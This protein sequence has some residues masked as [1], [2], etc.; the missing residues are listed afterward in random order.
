MALKVPAGA[1]LWTVRQIA[2]DGSVRDLASQQS[3]DVL[4]VPVDRPR[5]PN[6]A[7]SLEVTYAQPGLRGRHRVALVAPSL[8]DTPVTYASWEIEAGDRLAIG[9]AGGNMTPSDNGTWRLPIAGLGDGGKR[10]FYRTANLAG[11]EPLTVTAL[12]VPK[13]MAGGSATVLAGAGVAGL[14]LLGFALRRRR[15]LWW[16]LALTALAV[17]AVQTR[18]GVAGVALAGAFGV[19]VLLLIALVR[20]AVRAARRRRERR[21]AEQPADRTD[22]SDPSDVPP[23]APEPAGPQSGAAGVRLL[24]ALGV[25]AGVAV[26]AAGAGV[27]SKGGPVPA[28]AAGDATAAAKAEA[29][30]MLAEP[31]LP[32]PNVE[33][34]SVDVRAPSLDPRAERTAAVS[35]T[36]R[37]AAAGAGTYRVLNPNSVVVRAALPAGAALRTTPRG[38]SLDVARA[39][40]Y[41][42]TFET[43]EAVAERDG[44]W[45]LRLDLPPSLVNRFAL[46]VPAADMEVVSDQAVSHTTAGAAGETRVEGVLDTAQAVTF[47]WKPRAREARLEQAVVYCDVENVAFVR[48]GVVDV[49]A[50]ANYKI[51]QG[52]IRELRLKMPAGVS[53]T[54][55]AAPALATWRLDPAT[56]ELAA[57]LARPVSGDFTLTIGMQ[58]PCGGLPYGATLGVPAAENVQ[59]QRGL[60]A[61][62]AP[63][64]IL[65]RLGESKPGELEGVTPV[66]SSDFPVAGNAALMKAVAD[67]PL[68]RAFRYDDPATVKIALRAEPVQPELRVGESGSF[69]IGDERDVLSGVLDLAVAKSGVFS[70]KLQ[71]PADYDIDTLTG[72]DVSHWDDTRRSG[73]AVEVFFKRRV[74]GDTSINLV[75]TRPQRG[76]PEKIEVPRVTVQDA[77]RHTGRIGVSAERGVRLT[78]EEQQAVS[79]RK[80]EPGEKVQ[81]AALTFDILRPAWQVTLRTQVMAPTLKPEILHRVDLAEGMLQHRVYL[82][83]RIENAGVKYFRLRVPVKEATLS[84]S[85]RNIARVVPLDNDPEAGTGRVWQVELHGKVEDAYQLTGFY[86]QPFDP[87]AGGVAIQAFDCLGVARQSAWLVVTGGGRVQVEPRGEAEGLKIEDARSLPESF[88]AGD[89]SGAIRCYRALRP[90]Y[91]CDLSVVRNG[92]AAVL[93][94]SVDGAQFVTVLSSSGKLLTQAALDL[95]VGDLRFL[96]VELPSAGCSLWAAQVNGAQVAVSR[97][98]GVVNV[99]LENL[100]AD[101]STRVTLVYADRLAGAALDGRR[102]LRAPRFPD[103]PLRNI[104]WTLYVPPEYGHAFVEGDLDENEVVS[105]VKRFERS[106]YESYNKQVQVTSIEI[107]KSNLKNVS[108]LLDSGRQREA[109][110]AL[111]VAVNASQADQTLNEDARIQYRNVVRQQVKMGLVNRREELRRDNN[112]FDEQAPQTAL[113][114]NGGNFNNAFVSQ[115]EEQLS[116]Q[117]RTALDKVAG[118]IVEQQAAAAG[119]G[120]AINIAM[121]E[122]GRELCFRRALQGEKG[123]T[124]Q[125]V[126]RFK[127][128]AAAGRALA[129]WPVLPGF[130]VLWGALRLAAGRRKA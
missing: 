126:L 38:C 33:R 40:T 69:S 23:L 93:P 72:K 61:L 41:E 70:V 6:Q 85:G 75:L 31:P 25:A 79:V 118:R 128:P 114:F 64:S 28:Q 66:N 57:L 82:R 13:W 124:L 45:E 34:L 112:I 12:L 39:G 49:T 18:P 122:H 63:E 10:S 68:R 120:T 11:D 9:D 7:V 99:Q 56:R 43:R 77:A 115:V 88:G 119:Q 50:R 46:V 86:Q 27:A 92:A 29:G 105:T 74:L 35:W 129:F 101:K 84:V 1:S 58:A 67:E 102:A 78:V 110:Q 111:Q 3:G 98:A 52:E 117:D 76:I 109:Q 121:P 21:A 26:A 87:A 44:R 104:N 83:Y 36:M 130:L 60:F 73:Q 8:T 81:P 19:P 4:L 59:R 20:A 16:A 2:A 80:P 100:T 113:G 95:K 5:D 108:G 116:V 53:V 17:A 71:V 22:R 54:A 24:L 127:R 14:V 103:V 47:S 96:K 30:C 65:L 91:R 55:V 15:P 90:D 42:L 107:A 94:A 125:I 37:F 89:L 51:V 123:G 62:A 48:A 106:D 32:A 97:D